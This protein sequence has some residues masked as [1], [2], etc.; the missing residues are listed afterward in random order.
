M[1]KTQTI[2]LILLSFI[3]VNAF[4]EETPPEYIID[5]YIKLNSFSEKGD[6]IKKEKI[7]YKEVD[8]DHDGKLDWYLD[9]PLSC[10]SQGCNGQVYLLKKSKYCYGGPETRHTVGKVPNK[11]LKCVK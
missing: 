3:S 7:F 11:E 1:I 4:T 10:G 6:V 8:A 9:N 2:T 5:E